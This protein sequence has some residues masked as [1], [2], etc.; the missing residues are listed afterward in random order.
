MT[1]LVFIVIDDR[2]ICLFESPSGG[3][4]FFFW[5]PFKREIK[6]DGETWFV[7]KN[8]AHLGCAICCLLTTDGALGWQLINSF[9][10]FVLSINWTK[11]VWKS[12]KKVL[13]SPA[14]HKESLSLNH[15]PLSFFSLLFIENV[16]STWQ[17]LKALMP[18]SSHL[19][20]ICV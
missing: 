11:L 19:K 15:S 8:I 12:R 7:L 1:L 10:L 2:N 16:A 20:K 4:F 6:L 14:Q 17:H 5:F 13:L 18:N 9:C 3:G